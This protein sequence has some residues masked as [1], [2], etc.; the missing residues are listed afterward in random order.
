MKEKIKHLFSV[1]ANAAKDKIEHLLV[2]LAIAAAVGLPVY[3]NCNDLFAGIWS[4]LLSS[5]I[6]GSAKEWSDYQHDC[7]FDWK[8][9]AATCIGA[10]VVVLF[11]IC[12][13]FGK[14]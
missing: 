6:V 2:G 4:A 14:G 10:V 12:L 11:I 5:V 13:H 8:D 1:V 3:H 7:K 9:F